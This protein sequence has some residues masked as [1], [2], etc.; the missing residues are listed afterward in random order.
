MPFFTPKKRIVATIGYPG[1]GKSIFLAGLF[2]DSFFAL[3][4]TFQ[5]GTQPY[6]VR[7]LNE[8]ASKLFYGNAKLLY[9]LKLPP[10]NPRGK[11]EPAILEFKGIP[12][13]N[14]Q[15][16]RSTRL[17]FYDVAGEVFDDDR[18]T[19]EYAPYVANAHDLIF[20]FDPT[21]L[22]VNALWW[23]ELG[24][25][26]YRAANGDKKKNIIIALTKMDELRHHDDWWA[27]TINEHWPDATPTHSQLAL[28]LERMDSLS[29]TLRGWWTAEDRRGNNFINSVLETWP[30]T[31]FCALSSLGHQPVWDCP[32]CNIAIPSSLQV[33]GQCHTART[34]DLSLRLTREP[35]PFRVRDPLFWIFRAAGV[36]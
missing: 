25:R 1:H 16:R 29:A 10:A 33:C 14:S 8:E 11:P 28:Y 15:Q 5:D 24:D 36:M 3:S 34:N 26:I 19:R 27:Q 7:A 23:S 21:L 6:V 12:H 35:D 17:V 30:T 32:Q 13:A 4:R 18:K 22:E 9:D 20:L 31:R 2:W